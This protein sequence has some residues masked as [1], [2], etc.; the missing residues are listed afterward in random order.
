MNSIY[1]LYC[2]TCMLCNKGN[3]YLNEEYIS[4]DN[5]LKDEINDYRETKRVF[6]NN[7]GIIESLIDLTTEPTFI[8]DKILLGNGYNAR[9]F[10]ELEKNNVGLIINCS[11]DIPN[12][13]ENYFKYERVEVRDILGADISIYLNS[14]AD[15]IHK[16][17]KNYDTR[18]FIHCFMGSSR[19]ATIVIAYLMKYNNYSRRDA[20]NYLKELRPVVNINIDFFKQLNNY[21]KILNFKKI[22]GTITNNI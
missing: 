11:T 1:S 20:L 6:G 19:S 8:T 2:M 22:I 12:Y 5:L 14:M 10:Y 7:K 16:F 15:K 18:I 13:F 21:E 9:N 17:I 3:S 4:S